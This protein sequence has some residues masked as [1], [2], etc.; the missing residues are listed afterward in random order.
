MVSPKIEI[1]TSGIKV[2]VLVDGN[3]IHGVCGYSMSQKPGELPVLHLDVLGTR[4]DFESDMLPPIPE[5]WA[6]YYPKIKEAVLE[7]RERKAGRASFRETFLNHF[8]RRFEERQS[9]PK[10]EQ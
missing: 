3:E 8:N 7:L 1:K 5:P 2:Q 9:S 4:L 6:S 10:H